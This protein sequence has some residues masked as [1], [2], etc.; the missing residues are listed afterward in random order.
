MNNI[1]ICVSIWTGYPKK[2]LN[3][4]C[5]QLKAFRKKL[6][7]ITQMEKTRDGGIDPKLRWLTQKEAKRLKSLMKKI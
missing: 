3:K 4:F 6:K 5:G 2:F 1:K 7:E